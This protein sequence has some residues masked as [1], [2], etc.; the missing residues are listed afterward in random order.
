MVLWE[1]RLA[2][3]S[4]IAFRVSEFWHL[5]QNL[6]LFQ[7]PALQGRTY[8]RDEGPG[9]PLIPENTI[10]SGLLPLNS[11]LKSVFYD[12]KDRGSLQDDK[13][14]YVRLIFRTLLTNINGKKFRPPPPE[15]ILGAPQPPSAEK[16][17]AARPQRARH[18]RTQHYPA[19]SR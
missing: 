16:P 19:T 15:K 11:S 4:P 9:P 17:A 7:H 10:F 18:D 6:G 8:G 5:F 14:A 12:G 1:T 13:T 2:L 3:A